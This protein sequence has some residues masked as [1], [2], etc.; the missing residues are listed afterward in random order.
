MATKTEQN[1][2]APPANLSVNVV[3]QCRL[4]FL[5]AATDHRVIRLGQALRTEVFD[6]SERRWVE[7]GLPALADMG[8]WNP[9]QHQ[10]LFQEYLSERSR[11]IVEWAG[12]HNLAYEWVYALAERTFT[13]GWFPEKL[14]GLKPTDAPKITAPPWH[15]D[16]PAKAYESRFY[17]SIQQQFDRFIRDVQLSRAAFLNHKDPMSQASH[18]TWAAEHVC[19]GLDFS[20]IALKSKPERTPQG[21]RQAVL[22][23][24]ERIGVLP[25]LQRRT[26]KKRAV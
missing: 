10:P 17:D 19:L 1:A 22:P 25:H 8:T 7:L 3:T 9:V 26:A 12:S 20:A 18:Y 16:E 14:F 24:L 21:I 4:W 15:M 6:P 13:P 11:L 23:I 2:P 5:R